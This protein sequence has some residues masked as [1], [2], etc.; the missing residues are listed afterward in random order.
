MLTATNSE[1][2]HKWKE[3]AGGS[4]L[5]QSVRCRADTY[6]KDFGKV[7]CDN[8]KFADVSVTL[9]HDEDRMGPN[10]LSSSASRSWT[11]KLRIQP[12]IKALE[13]KQTQKMESTLDTLEPETRQTIEVP[14]VGRPEIK[15]K[16]IAPTFKTAPAGRYPKPQQP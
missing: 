16:S 11:D 6:G 7:G 12:E 15:A 14:P 10:D 13:I 9:N 3:Y 4:G 2:N 8:I 5:V 1:D